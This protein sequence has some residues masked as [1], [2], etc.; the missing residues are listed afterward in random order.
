[1]QA[2]R[3]E[4]LEQRAMFDNLKKAAREAL[5]PIPYVDIPTELFHLIQDGEAEICAKIAEERLE[6]SIATDEFIAIEI[7]AAI[8]AR[9]AARA[10]G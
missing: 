9:I 5:Q 8:R 3:N 6:Y 4:A 1:M 2:V 10:K 7:A